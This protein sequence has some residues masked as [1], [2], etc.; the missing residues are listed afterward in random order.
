[1]LLLRFQEEVF[2]VKKTTHPGSGITHPGS[3]SR[4]QGV[5][6]P[7]ILDLE[8]GSATLVQIIAKI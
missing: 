7:R 3:G 8:S 2:T 6:K 4:I 5:K 1:M